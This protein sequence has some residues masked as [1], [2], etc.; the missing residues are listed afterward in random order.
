MNRKLLLLF[1]LFHI[2][3][4]LSEEASHEVQPSTAATNITV[5]GTVFCDACSEN[6]FSNHSYFLQGV[7]VQIM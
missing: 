4:L 7:K 3:F 2:S 1:F 5:V 6:T